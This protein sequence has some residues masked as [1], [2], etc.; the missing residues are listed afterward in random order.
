MN[1]I[2]T[3]RDASRFV[4]AWRRVVGVFREEGASNAIFVWAPNATDEPRA[5]WNHWTAYYPGDRYVDW[6]GIDGYNWGST[7]GG[8]W[9]S[10][11]SIIRPIY[12]DYAARKPIMIA[13]TSSV[14]RDDASKAQWITNA[15]AWMKAHPAVAAFVW[16]DIRKERNW[17]ID[18]TAAS[19][20]A[21]K[22]LAKDPYFTAAGR[23]NLQRRR[24]T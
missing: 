18:S 10:F 12:S 17:R 20:R 22:T 1:A 15:R 3:G 21:F 8:T 9:Q 16:F 2:H 14:E 24:T 13:E 19:L 6:V 7:V 5:S 4:L 23:A 11:S